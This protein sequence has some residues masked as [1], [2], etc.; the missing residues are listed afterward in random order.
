MVV[1]E[2]TRIALE[3]LRYPSRKT[4]TQELGLYSTFPK[5]YEMLQE[6]V[7]ESE[8]EKE[9]CEKEGDPDY[10]YAFTLGYAITKKRL[11]VLYGPVISI[12]TYTRDGELN[13]ESIWT[14]EKGTDPFPFY[15]RPE[16]KI[17]FKMGDIVE[18]HMRGYAEL[19]IVS[20]T[21]WTPQE[22]E[23]RNKELEKR[24]GKGHTLTLDSYDDCYL[25]HSLGLGNTH[26]HPVCSELFAPTKKVPAKIR[27]K[28][29]AKLLE[30]N[31]TFGYHLQISE[32]PFVKD[33]KVLDELLNGWDKFIDAKYYDG[34][35]C[36]VDY[37]NA[38]DIKAAL[39]F[40]EEQSLRFDRFYEACIRLVN[41]KRENKTSKP[42]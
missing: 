13:D 5:A 8:K 22:I 14:D 33:P 4:Q 21:P 34:M 35:E 32:L 6:L 12:Q 18:V 19:S 3:T 30:E 1:F 2:L 23:R 37:E 15:G 10:N 16:E 29:Q 7:L 31:F 25:T 27:R 9:E 40:S 26:W 11:D 28:L 17:R 38:D 42:N 41:E 24:R 20:S 36:L 39:S